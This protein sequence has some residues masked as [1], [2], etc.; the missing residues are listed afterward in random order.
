MQFSF[1]ASCTKCHCSYDKHDVT[2]PSRDAFVAELELAD[3]NLLNA[4]ESAQAV[5]K[6]HGLNWLPV[7]INSAEVSALATHI[8]YFFRHSPNLLANFISNFD[9]D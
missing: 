3:T 7:G 8:S 5:A 9:L 4:Y 6:E 1:R 2:N